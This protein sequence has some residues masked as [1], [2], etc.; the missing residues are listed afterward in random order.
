M[1]SLPR[2]ADSRRDAVRTRAN[3]R[4]WY[5]LR[6]LRACRYPA[7]I[8][9]VS[10]YVGP[11]VGL[12]L[13]VAESA[14]RDR[15]VPALSGCGAIE[16]DP[17]SELVCLD[18]RESFADRVRRAIDAGVLTHLKPPRLKRSRRGVFY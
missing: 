13:D 5:A 7:T 6:Y 15:D 12:S 2:G 16:Y 17:Q 18:D 11:P 10:E 9:E 8:P 14:L 4:R 3:A 1:A